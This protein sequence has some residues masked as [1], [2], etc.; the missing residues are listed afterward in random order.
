MSSNAIGAVKVGS[1]NETQRMAREMSTIMGK[2]AMV[3]GHQGALLH[4]NASKS[5][6]SISKNHH[7]LGWHAF[8]S[9]N[10]SMGYRS[11]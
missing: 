3:R 2:N 10:I 4:H 9:S 8:G 6:I 5:R 1:E 7:T 11:R